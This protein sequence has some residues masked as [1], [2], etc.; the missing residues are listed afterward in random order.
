MATATTRLRDLLIREGLVSAAQVEDALV[1]MKDR[2]SKLSETLIDIGYLDANALEE[3]IVRQPS[4]VGLDISQRR[5]VPELCDLIPIEL[6][7]KHQVFPID[8]MG[9]LLTVAMAMPLDTET[10]E[11]LSNASGLR[12]NAIY[13]KAAHIKGAIERYYEPPGSNVLG[14]FSGLQKR[15]LGAS[16]MVTIAELLR[17]ID[18]MPSLPDT[19][20]RT[21]EALDNPMIEIEVVEKMIERDPLV[22]GKVLKLANSAAFKLS[23]KID[24]VPMAIRLLGLQEVY[25]IVLAS[26]VLSMAESTK[27]FDFNRFWQESLFCAAA[28]PE[29]ADAASI[30]RSPALSTAALLHD[31]GQ[32]ALAHTS[33]QGYNSIDHTKSGKE[34]VAVEENVLGLTHTEAGFAVAQHWELPEEIADLIRHHHTPERAEQSKK[35]AGV[36]TLAAFLSEAHVTEKDL[37]SPDSFDEVQTAMDITGVSKNRLIEVYG[38]VAKDMA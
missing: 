25:N 3:F 33:P 18:D 19:V 20:L 21:K 30:K 5:V 14:K 2:D 13:C 28:L 11:E 32:F 10:I 9:R 37:K 24:N 6:A 15:A 31:I 12:V 22:A 7:R 23:R 38:H 34:L 26:S 1:M 8:R 29:V 36:I 17:K 27:G 35:E 4:I 16:T